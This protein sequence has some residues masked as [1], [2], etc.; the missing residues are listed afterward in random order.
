MIALTAVSL[1]FVRAPHAHADLAAV[2]PSDALTFGTGHAGVEVSDNETTV[3]THKINAGHVG[4]M[5]HFWSTCGPEVEAGLLVRY[6]VDGETTASIAFTPPLA[7]GVGFDDADMAPWG[8][9]WFGLGAGGKRP[10][11]QAWFHNFKVP[12]RSSI[13]VTVQSPSKTQSKGFYIILRGGL[14]LGIDVGGVRLPDDAKL[15]LQVFEGAVKPLA[16]VDVAHVPAGRSGLVFASTLAVNNSGVGGVNFLEGLPPALRPADAGV[17][18]HAARDGHRGLLRQRLVFQRGRL[19][20]A[21]ER[22]DA[23]DHR[24]EQDG[25]ER[26]PGAGHGP[27]ALLRRRALHVALRR[28]RLSRPRRR[29]VLHRGAEQR[30]DRRQPDVRPRDDLRV[31]LQLAEALAV[32]GCRFRYNA[33]YCPGTHSDCIV[34]YTGRRPVGPALRNR[35]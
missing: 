29:K 1:S 5:T 14:D 31:G 4:V 3:F 11:G 28:R 24:E 32:T 27:S 22:D 19:R 17:A 18:R 13:V 34:R 30:Q 6:Y 15:E 9:R 2:E 10:A 25:V 20:D 21:G 12:F 8:T 23:P 35:L 26:V 7:A 33:R 16:F